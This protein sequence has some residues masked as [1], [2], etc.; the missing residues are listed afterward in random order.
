MP[1]K[2]CMNK[3]EPPE[4]QMLLIVPAQKR[5]AQ[6]MSVPHADV[7]DPS[8]PI[9]KYAEPPAD[10]G[11]KFPQFAQQLHARNI[12]GIHSPAPQ[13]PECIQ[14][15]GIQS[16]RFPYKSRHIYQFTLIEVGKE[17]RRAETDLF[18]STAFLPPEGLQIT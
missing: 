17:V 3:P 11:R 5:K 8:A 2:P 10:S 12:S 9:K 14:S 18:S 15:G 6:R 13:A 16:C 1:R 7:S 4:S